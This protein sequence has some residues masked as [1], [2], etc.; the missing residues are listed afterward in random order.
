MRSRT[1][2]HCCM[3]KMQNKASTVGK[4]STAARP[5]KSFHQHKQCYSPASAH[6]ILNRVAGQFFSQATQGER[7]TVRATLTVWCHKT[8]KKDE[9]SSGLCDPQVTWAQF[10]THSHSLHSLVRQARPACG[11]FH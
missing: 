9:A 6:L 4:T 7:V 11:E 2:Q 3:H 1:Y 10:L 5:C 8:V